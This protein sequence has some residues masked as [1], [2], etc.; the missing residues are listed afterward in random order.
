MNKL[1]H[2]DIIFFSLSRWD[3]QI[4]SM[5]F[6]MAIELAKNNR[7]FYIDHPFTLKDYIKEHKNSQI[8]ARKEALWKGTNIFTPLF[9]ISPKL[10][11][12]CTRLMLPINFLPD[13]KLYKALSKFNDSMVFDT[14]RKIIKD[15]KIENF[16]FI[17]AFDPFYCQH[18]PSDIQPILKIYQSMDDISQASYTAK[19]GTRLE[20]Q[21]IR[22]YS[23]T[24]TT[25]KELFK[26]KKQWSDKVYYLP[27]AADTSIFSKSIFE[28]Q[29]RPA[30]LQG[31]ENKKI[32]GYT[33]NIESRI[34]YELLKK[35]IETY[36]AFIFCLV[37]P[38]SS[39][40][41]E[42]IGLKNYPNVILTGAKKMNQLPQ[43]LH[44]FD[45]CIIPFKKNKLTKSIYPLKINEY[46]SAGR[47]VVT[48]DF[49]EDIE[50]FSSVVTISK[51]HQEFMDAISSQISNNEHATQIER[52]KFASHNTW[53]ARVKDF[54][55]IIDSI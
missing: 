14:I 2:C 15:K 38:I 41:H 12:V 53:E 10:E 24:L 40:D 31:L 50:A 23:L 45:C 43:Y 11:A 19:H 36:P 13:S 51:T 26:L 22:N 47:A 48:T 55:K 29:A 33:G 30:E 5:P 7:V 8:K 18:F 9:E 44:F 34:D 4:S 16:I 46:L 52:N 49:S 17:N 1:Q 54:W 39:N 25:S 3:D 42:T 27:N 28:P 20:Q 37:G 35:C 32:I 21:M 6:S